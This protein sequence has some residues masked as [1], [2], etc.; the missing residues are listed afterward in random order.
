MKCEGKKLEANTQH[1]GCWLRINPIDKYMGSRI[2][3]HTYMG[4]GMNIDLHSR[5]MRDYGGL[6]KT[7][8]WVVALF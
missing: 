5:S 8:L 7:L 2:W 6:H 1:V 4:S 3:G